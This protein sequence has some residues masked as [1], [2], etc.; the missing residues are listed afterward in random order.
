MIFVDGCDQSVS[1]RVKKSA[2]SSSTGVWNYFAVKEYGKSVYLQNKTCYQYVNST[3][4]AGERTLMFSP[5]ISPVT[6]CRSFLFVCSTTNFF[7][8]TKLKNK[9]LICIYNINSMCMLHIVEA[10]SKFNVELQRVVLRTDIE[11]RL[12]TNLYQPNS[13]HLPQNFENC[14]NA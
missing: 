14:T 9:F 6:G 5:K 8:K 12:N 13:S 4:H 10:N 11:D 2:V 7:F 1:S 3:E